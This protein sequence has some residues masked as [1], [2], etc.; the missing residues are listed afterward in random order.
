RRAARIAAAARWRLPVTARGCS[1]GAAKVR[2]TRM[3]PPPDAREAAAPA[4][5]D[6]R[7]RWYVRSAWVRRR[8]AARR[9]AVLVVHDRALPEE[10]SAVAPSL[11]PAPPA[12]RRGSNATPIAAS[13]H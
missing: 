3:R 6:A 10:R 4:A 8:P 11:P 9:R 5:R 2:R 1:D 12:Q 13:R 7:A